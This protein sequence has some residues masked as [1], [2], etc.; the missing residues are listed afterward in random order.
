MTH[1]YFLKN[2]CHLL[3]VH[4]QITAKF[5]IVPALQEPCLVTSL[6]LVWFSISWLPVCSHQR[7]SF[8]RVRGHDV[9][10]HH[11]PSGL[12]PHRDDL[13][14]QED[15]S[16]RGRSIAGSSV[17]IFTAYICMH[18]HVMAL[19]TC[20]KLVSPLSRFVSD[21]LNDH[22]IFAYFF[23]QMSGFFIRLM[24]TFQWQKNFQGF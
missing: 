11:W 15:S 18:I 8:H 4:F 7:N 10:V 13:L 5:Q 21:L 9:R 3:F 19:M 24:Q 14:L 16:S 1:S 22:S 12:A 17:S 6:L 23:L 2:K 20:E